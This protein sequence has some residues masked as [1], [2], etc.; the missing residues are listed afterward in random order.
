MEQEILYP[1][2]RGK[3]VQRWSS[4][5]VLFII[6]PQDPDKR[7]NGLA[8]G[9]LK[10]SYPLTFEYLATFQKALSVRRTYQKFL[11]PQGLPFYSLYDI[12]NYTF[13]PFKVVWKEVSTRIDATVISQ[14]N[15]KVIVPDHK[16]VFVSFNNDREAHYFC[17]LMNSSIVHAFVKA[18]A[19]STQNAPKLLK[20]ISIPQFLGSELHN[21][22]SDLSIQCH[23]KAS[24]GIDCKDLEQQI[25]ELAAEIWGL[26]RDELAH[27]EQQN[28]ARAS[29]QPAKDL[30]RPYPGRGD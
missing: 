25:D 20:E 10:A 17:A 9:K 3:D 26:D 1:L 6:I 14:T 5:Q 27:L 12:K 13:D 28:M 29:R 24:S 4:E 23:E 19:I 15:G 7:Q 22:L 18:S 16:L 8:L 30:S 21:R 2:L 11:Q